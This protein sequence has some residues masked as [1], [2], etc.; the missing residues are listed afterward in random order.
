MPAP[1]TLILAS[2]SR[3]R[4]Q[5]LR[6]AGF[7]C[8]VQTPLFDDPADPSA[9]GEN[10]LSPAELAQHLARH[11]ALS[12]RGQTPP[13]VV[14][15]AADTIVVVPTDTGFELLGQPG[16]PEEA[17]RIIEKL[18]NRVH[19]VVTGVALM[20][21]DGTRLETFADTARVHLG[22]VSESQLEQHLTDNA[23]RG[24][25]GGYNLDELRDHWPFRVEGDET[26]VVGLP[27][28]KLMQRLRDWGIEPSEEANR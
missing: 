8:H 23:W 2:R 19:E 16:T 13:D 24:K 25:A 22:N 26:T 1:A 6:E 15:L 11:K 9:N 14:I 18:A 7:A 3:R 12:M 10:A 4:A 27:M 21:G 20:S 28:V 17:R 5:L